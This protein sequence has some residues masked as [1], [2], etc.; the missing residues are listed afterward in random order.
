MWN[1]EKSSFVVTMVLTLAGYYVNVCGPHWFNLRES[2][3]SN[4]YP[5]FKH[6]AR[7]LPL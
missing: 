3:F 4:V 7:N 2:T 1:I 6:E 5:P